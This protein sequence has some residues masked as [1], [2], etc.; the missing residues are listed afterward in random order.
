MTVSGDTFRDVLGHFASGVTVVTTT[1]GEG[2]AAGLT[3][4]AFSALSLDPPLVLVCVGYKSY[5]YQQLRASEYFAIHI[6][7]DDQLETALSFARSG[8]HKA[9][10]IAW[11]ADEH[12][13]PILDHYH[14][15]IR[16]RNADE[17]PGGDHAILIGEVMDA[18]IPDD[19]SDPLTYYRGRLQALHLRPEESVEAGTDAP[20]APQDAPYR[21]VENRPPV[22]RPGRRGDG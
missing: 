9:R 7:S 15:L 3:A 4:S 5:A 1:D 16:C 14:A 12:G 22:P 8:P 2:G 19:G 10:E 17:Y 11:K 6:L 13:T 20:C 18:D 21:P